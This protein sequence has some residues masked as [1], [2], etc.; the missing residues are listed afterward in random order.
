MSTTSKVVSL[1]D[2]MGSIYPALV[3]DIIGSL[4]GETIKQALLKE[5]ASKPNSPSMRGAA[6][7]RVRDPR[8]KP[9]PDWP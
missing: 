4:E 3:R 2:N 8:S 1:V 5:E 9:S 6:H 7:V